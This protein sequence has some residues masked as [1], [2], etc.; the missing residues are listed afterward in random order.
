M[1]NDSCWDMGLG[2][3]LALGESGRNDARHQSHDRTLQLFPNPTHGLL[4]IEYA[5]PGPQ[6]GAR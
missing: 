6:A 1:V 2:L 3:T 5:V 4:S